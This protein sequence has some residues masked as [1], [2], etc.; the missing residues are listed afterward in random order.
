MS[1]A[2]GAIPSMVPTQSC[3]SQNACRVAVSSS[4]LTGVILRTDA[5]LYRT[6]PGTWA[7]I[8]PSDDG[9]VPITAR[10]AN[11]RQPSRASEVVVFWLVHNDLDHLVYLPRGDAALTQRAVVVCFSRSRKRYERQ[12]VLVEEEAPARAEQACLSDADA[13]TRARA[14]AA[15]RRQT[16]DREYVSAFPRGVGA[17]F[18][19]CPVETQRA[20][21]EHACQEYSGRVGRSAAAKARQAN[22]VELAVR[23]HVRHAYTGYDV[24]VR[25]FERGE[26]IVHGI[27]D[28]PTLCI[29]A[30]VRS[31]RDVTGEVIDVVQRQS[32]HDLGA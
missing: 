9:P 10:V 6:I 17:R 2:P 27:E 15:D 25:G 21:A 23:A 30:V 4:T 14:R 16:L 28:T 3:C 20:I 26:P 8:S 7:G 11:Q 32:R 24:R 31:R 1:Q 22:A 5:W 19:G 29:L 12:G 13:R 18:P